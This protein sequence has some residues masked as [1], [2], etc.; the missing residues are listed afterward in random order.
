[1]EKITAYDVAY[2][3]YEKYKSDFKY[4]NDKWYYY[5]VSQETWIENKDGSMVQSKIATYVCEKY[6]AKVYENNK[7]LLDDDNETIIAKNKELIA[8]I[9]KL[10]TASFKKSIMDECKEFYYDIHS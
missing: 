9:Q 1:M 8:F 7:E 2:M 5:D 3:I 4:K 10:Y 6:M